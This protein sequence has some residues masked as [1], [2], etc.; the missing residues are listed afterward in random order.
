MG[1]S[2]E[3]EVFGIWK[4]RKDIKSSIDW[5]RNNERK[6][7]K[8][9]SKKRNEMNP[10]TLI[11]ASL[12]ILAMLIYLV[13][14][15][16]DGHTDLPHTRTV[17]VW[18]EPTHVAPYEVSTVF[19]KVTEDG[20]PAANISIYFHTNFGYLIDNRS[21]TY[22]TLTNESGLASVR[23]FAEHSGTATVTAAEKTAGM[24]NK[25]VIVV[26]D[27]STSGGNGN[28]GSSNGGTTPTPSPTPT[29][30]PTATPGANVTPTASSQS[31][32]PTTA[33]PIATP[34]LSPMAS[35][36]ETPFTT[37]TPSPTSVPTSTSKPLMPVPGFEAVFAISGLLAVAYLVRR[38][39]K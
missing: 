2:G 16:D 9:K 22:T 38:K 26:R 12:V 35:P 31:P 28:G 6:V 8:N 19:V 21:T 13:T 11:A 5:V 3:I 36:T 37:V 23:F 32:S 39:M 27:A 33:S 4:D 14:G 20:T 10:K 24:S 30:S 34:T 15:A 18:A 7:C 17:D 1:I 25:T 29:A